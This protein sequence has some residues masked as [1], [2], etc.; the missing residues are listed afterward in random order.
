MINKN[1]I[2]N[3]WASIQKRIVSTNGNLKSLKVIPVTKSVTKEEIEVLISL[4][5]TNFAENR[6]DNLK[7]KIIK[8][9]NPNILWDFIGNIQSRK[10]SE[11]ISCSHLIHSVGNNDLLTK[12]NASAKQTSKITNILIQVNIAEE[13]QKS[14]FTEQEIKQK[15]SEYLKLENIKIIGLM[16]MAPQTNDTTI[17][18]NTFSGLRK[19]RDLLKQDAPSSFQ[20]LSM[21]MSNDFEIAIQEGATILRIGSSF[22]KETEL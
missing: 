20:E 14:G 5:F 11:I 18:K 17:I 9:N 16:T 22:F 3:N 13:T 7:E 10:I 1:L 21:G 8:I 2:I 4:G 19:L 12:I 15:F 6:I